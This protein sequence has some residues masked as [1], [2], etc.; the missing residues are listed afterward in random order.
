MLVA[1]FL[2]VLQVQIGPTNRHA[3]NIENKKCSWTALLLEETSCY[4]K[5]ISCTD[6]V[7]INNAI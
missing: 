5:I 1:N 4:F 6:V 3:V 7:F 2:S